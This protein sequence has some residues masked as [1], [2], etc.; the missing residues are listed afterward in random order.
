M[1]AA[2]HIAARLCAVAAMVASGCSSLP[3]VDVAAP[4]IAR[5]YEDLTQQEWT[6]AL[7]LADGGTA[8]LEG[9]ILTVALPAFGIATVRIG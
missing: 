3:A 7:E 8:R 6:L 2:I 9:Q 1:R 4:D 5:R